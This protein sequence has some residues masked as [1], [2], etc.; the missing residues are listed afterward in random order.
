MEMQ[1]DNS[2]VGEVGDL[3]GSAMRVPALMEIDIP[4]TD[5]FRDSRGIPR[6]FYCSNYGHVKN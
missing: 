5:V 6:C 2:A 1:K 4:K 3:D